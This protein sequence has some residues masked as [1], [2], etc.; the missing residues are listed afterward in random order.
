[1]RISRATD[2]ANKET[3]PANEPILAP[4][5][6]SGSLAHLNLGVKR[7]EDVLVVDLSIKYEPKSVE[8]VAAFAEYKEQLSKEIC[9]GKLL[10]DL[11]AKLQGTS[12]GDVPNPK[13]T[14][15]QVLL[16]EGVTPP[17]AIDSGEVRGLPSWVIGAIQFKAEPFKQ[18]SAAQ[19]ELFQKL[20]PPQSPNDSARAD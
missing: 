20:S 19:Q 2:P 10:K 13:G 5:M 14:L 11:V 9:S 8:E 7:D 17:D 18:P 16:P 15:V 6:H 3:N 12:W 4:W 1:M